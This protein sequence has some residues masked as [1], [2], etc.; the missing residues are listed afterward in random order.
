MGVLNSY[1]IA[2]LF[3][4]PFQSCFIILLQ[5]C[6]TTLFSVLSH[7]L[8]GGIAML[9][10]LQLPSFCL[11]FLL[12]MSILPHHAFASSDKMILPD[13]FDSEPGTDAVLVIDVS[14]S[15]KQSDPGYLCRQAAMD[16][17]KEL[18][19][20]AFSRVGLITFC[21]FVQ[22]VIPLTGLDNQAGEAELADEIQKLEY[23]SGDTDIGEAM[24]KAV[25]L[26]LEDKND[27]RAKCIL[28]LTDGEIDLPGQNEEEAEKQSLTDALVAVEDAKNHGI[29]I[30][31]V[32]LD[33]SGRLDENLMHYMADSTGGS[34]NKV[35]S[36]DS[37]KEVFH[38]L[39][40]QAAI[41]RDKTAETETEA[42]TETFL[43]EEETES[44]TETQRVP[45]VVHTIG[46]IDGPVQLK[47][48][49]PSLSSASLSLSDLFSLESGTGKDAG[50]VRYT[51]YA[52]DSSLLSCSVEGDLL[53]ITG[54]ENGL[55]GITVIAEP[56]LKEE[57]PSTSGISYGAMDPVPGAAGEDPVTGSAA[58][59]FLVDVRALIGS[60][61]YLALIPACIAL[62]LVLL[63]LS[64]SR[65]PRKEEGL[66]SGYLQ[67]YVRGENERIFG[68]PSQ[69]RASLG[70]Y[71]RKVRLSELVRDDLLQD[72]DLS[73]VLISA[74]GSGIRVISHS[75]TILL[76]REGGEP[77][78]S[79]DMTCSGRFKVFCETDRGRAAVI[80]L[81]TSEKEYKTEPSFE[82]D[83]D[84]RTRLLV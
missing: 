26:L 14:G 37:L 55:T 30:H 58:I 28:L 70:N 12:V 34:A 10:S 19:H 33:H 76:A 41:L 67:W 44:E 65:M 31:T 11:V 2:I 20:T 59:S 43:T 25:S 80:A 18:S 68:M 46:T 39:S 64:R 66:L 73:K 27:V 7:F 69:T 40:E 56:D 9:R 21:D 53:T 47:G 77:G 78:N 49:L 48:L 72:A 60:P 63:M 29:V 5:S 6:F 84:E 42:L 50:S 36:A 8:S 38:A 51:A 81:Y 54:R 71:G 32:S 3:H 82:D 4:H 83:S 13:P 22:K 1:I 61:L 74:Y 15:M 35:T 16:F 52:D 75:R 23:T 79:L 45:L 62:V 57:D 17:I 24:Q